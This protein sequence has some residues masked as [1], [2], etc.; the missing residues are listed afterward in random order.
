MKSSSD[1]F[2]E[3]MKERTVRSAGQPFSTIECTMIVLRKCGEVKSGRCE[4]DRLR[5]LN[6]YSGPVNDAKPSHRETTHC[7]TRR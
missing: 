2:V 6:V 5:M 3:I 4:N 7:T 1:R